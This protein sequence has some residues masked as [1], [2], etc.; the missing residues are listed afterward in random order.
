MGKRVRS[1]QLVITKVQYAPADETS[2]RR[3][4]AVY[5]LLLRQS[6]NGSGKENQ[7]LKHA[8]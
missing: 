1:R 7:K 4:G 8:K 6:S 5:K 3:I 2:R